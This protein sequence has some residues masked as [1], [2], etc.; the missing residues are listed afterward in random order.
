M[1]LNKH[2]NRL[3]KKFSRELSVKQKKKQK[4][5]FDNEARFYTAE[6]YAQM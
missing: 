3:K 5:I 6:D 2:E 4:K 1:E